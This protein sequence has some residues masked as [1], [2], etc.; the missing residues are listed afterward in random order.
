MTTGQGPDV[1]VV[2]YTANH[3]EGTKIFLKK[4]MEKERQYHRDLTKNLSEEQ[5]QK[6]VEYMRNYYSARKK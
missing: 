1:F 5:K 2:I 6:K 3:H 4:K